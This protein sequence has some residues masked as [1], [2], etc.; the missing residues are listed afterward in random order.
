MKFRVSSN[1]NVYF[2]KF[3]LYY[4]FK[5]SNSEMKNFW[6]EFVIET[7]TNT[8]VRFSRASLLAASRRVY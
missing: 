4:D 8:V 7:W 2:I 5:K 1:C 6:I 3:I